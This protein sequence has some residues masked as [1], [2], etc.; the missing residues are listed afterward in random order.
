MLTAE[1]QLSLSET[2]AIGEI[3]E[4]HFG[5]IIVNK[6]G[7]YTHQ[8]QVAE[9]GLSFL[10]FPGGTLAERANVI[11]GALILNDQSVTYE[12]LIGD[13]SN[14]GFDLTHPELISPNAL[15][16]GGDPNQPNDVISFSTAL[17]F[18]IDSDTEFNLVVPVQRYISGRD[19]SDPEVVSSAEEMARQDALIFAERLKSGAYNEGVLPKNLLIDIGNEIYN[20]PFAYAIIAKVFI[21][22]LTEELSGTGIE[23][24]LGFQMG[25]GSNTH[26][27]LLEEGYFEAYLP[28]GVPKIDAMVGFT[29][30]DQ[31]TTHFDDRITFVD[32][33]MLYILGD[34]A[35]NIDY[36]RH[37]H[38]AVDI[39]LLQDENS[40]FHQREQ[41]VNLWQASITDIP[42]YYVSAW[43]TDAS[44]AENLPYSLAGAVNAL[45]IFRNFAQTGVD[46]AALW[47]L[48]GA[49]NYSPAEILPT[50][51]SD[52]TSD[53]TSP[54]LAVLALMSANIENSHLL[55]IGTE[56]ELVDGTNSDFLL[57]AYESDEAFVLYVAVGELD[58]E[59]L[60][61]ELGI[62]GVV[63]PVVQ[64]VQHLE[65]IGGD[66]SGAAVISD[67]DYLI[68]GGNLSVRFDQDFEIAQII[69]PKSVG[70]ETHAER[71]ALDELSDRN[72]LV[73]DVTPLVGNGDGNVIVGGSN[74][75]IIFGRDGNDILSGG[76]GRVQ[77]FSTDYNGVN[78]VANDIIF[79][80]FGDD[81]LLGNDG[82][83]YLA[84]QQGN[85]TL[86]G[87]GGADTFVFTEGQD[88]ITD[89]D[90]RVDHIILDVSQFQTDELTIDY[91]STIATHEGDNVVLTF[92]NENS[93]TLLGAAEDQVD[94]AFFDYFEF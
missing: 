68:D 8:E 26:R 79:A 14:I 67:V 53:I 9:Y 15:F 2:D 73:T 45:A 88:T 44:N 90:F 80:G 91:L 34:S 19:F 38:L 39:D 92:D 70:I 46:R 72:I 66:V 57:F 24:E 89:F 36:V 41:I 37:H 11:D 58:G 84:G 55:S 86:T 32:R 69:L 20:D 47:G 17:Q 56:L 35:E 27:K 81:T 75:D 51:I 29:S 65:I 83:D 87:G 59:E 49:F 28:N 7:A 10:R 40:I 3:T 50:V 94:L 6:Y 13:R 33:G 93:L 25:N 77:Y 21:D 23:Y 31:S 12:M 22:T 63:L 64:T 74:G 48:V 42:D 18:A 71:G 60:L 61:L 1:Y 5:S 16:E 52:N 82:S 76:N 78:A 43:T 30:E 85:D 4:D 54:S 62:D